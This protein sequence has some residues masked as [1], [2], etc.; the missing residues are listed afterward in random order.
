MKKKIGKNKIKWI[1]LITILIIGIGAGA[2]WAVI[3]YQM[4]LIPSMTLEEMI[5]YT[6]E[7]N[8]DAIITIGIIQNGEM[9]YTVYGKDATVLP[10]VEYNYEIGSLTK[11]FTASL[12]SKAMSEGKIDLNNQINEYMELPEKEYYPTLKELVTHTSGY[13]GFY[14][15]WQMASNFISKQENDFYGVT[16]D[17]LI[18]KLGEINLKDKE[19]DFKYS[20][21]GFA[22]VGRVLSNVYGMDY[23]TL[24]NQFITEDLKLKDTRI[25]DGTGDLNGYWEWKWDDAYIPA[26]GINSN[27]S[28]M[29]QYINLQMSGNIPYLDLG[30]QVIMEI[31]ATTNQYAKMN[32]RMDAIGIGWLM[33][34]KNNIIWHNGGTSNFNS[35]AAFD[36]EKQIGVVILSNCSPKY[37]IPT[38]VMGVKLM[39][40][41]Q[42]EA[43]KK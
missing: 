39:M 17:E 28:D 37:R 10:N 32:I 42:D 12:L 18:N 40:M 19:Y 30:Q 35:Y 16:N 43:N 33:D 5:A 41:L 23:T 21:F 36:K 4:S 2:F 9:T 27:I 22:T 7:K 31:D 6:T 3:S 1:I 29:M 34:E 38:T 14:F 15:E 11:T 20:N 13:K 24:M 25:A 8:E 26:G